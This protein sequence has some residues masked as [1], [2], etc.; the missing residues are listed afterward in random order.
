[1]PPLPIHIP[2]HVLQPVQREPERKDPRLGPVH[3]A[4]QP[5]RG[6]VDQE[7]HLAEVAVREGEGEGGEDG[8]EVVEEGGEL[9]GESR[10]EGGGERGEGLGELGE[11]RWGGRWGWG[12]WLLGAVP[13]LGEEPVGGMG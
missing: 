3:D 5:A 6:G 9:G 13:G 7:I 8:G 11:E 2:Q 4:C 1:M 10:G 12:G